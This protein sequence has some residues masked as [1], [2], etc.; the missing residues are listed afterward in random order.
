MN[1]VWIQPVEAKVAFLFFLPMA[2]STVF[3]K[4]RLD[5][6]GEFA[7][8]FAQYRSGSKSQKRHVQNRYVPAFNHVLVLAPQVQLTASRA[9]QTRCKL[10]RAYQ[11]NQV[12]PDNPTV[13][14]RHTH[15]PGLLAWASCSGPSFE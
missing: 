1:D 14:F 12:Y 6:V 15:A 2:A 13:F 8:G 4:Y 7:V 11:K 10:A 3:G 9:G 5:R